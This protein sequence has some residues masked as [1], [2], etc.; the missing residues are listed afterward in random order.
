MKMD[1]CKTDDNNVD[2]PESENVFSAVYDNGHINN[3]AYLNGLFGGD[4][5]EIEKHIEKGRLP[6]DKNETRFIFDPTLFSVSGRTHQFLMLLIEKF[7][8]RVSK[9]ASQSLVK[10]NLSVTLSYAEI[11]KEFGVTTKAAKAIADIACLSLQ[12]TLICGKWEDSRYKDTET[13]NILCNS[14]THIDKLTRQGT[15]TASFSPE[16]ADKMKSMYIMWYPK[17]IRKIPLRKHPNANGFMMYL[18]FRYNINYGKECHRKET[19]AGLLATTKSIPDKASLKRA[20]QVH[21]RIITPFIRDMN[22]LVQYGLLREW[23]FVYNE[24][25]IPVEEYK[26]LKYNVFINACVYYDMLIYP[27]EQRIRSLLKHGKKIENLLLP[28]R[29]SEQPFY[30]KLVEDASVNA[31]EQPIP[32]AG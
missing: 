17:R 12:T 10:A 9:T 29:V 20:C 21:K 28:A 16:F 25:R 19:V 31:T 23:Y 26:N 7:T 6:V 24:K 14:K 30:K 18:A 32:A 15:V 27:D 5:K 13:V 3:L 11:A 8:I 22:V 1:N 2:M 4:P